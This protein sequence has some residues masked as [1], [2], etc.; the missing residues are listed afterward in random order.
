MGYQNGLGGTGTFCAQ[1]LSTVVHCGESTAAIAMVP[2]AA[3]TVVV[4]IA[5]ALA[6]NELVANGIGQS[7]SC[8]LQG[9]LTI[10]QCRHFA[11]CKPA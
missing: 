5:L 4:P 2:T 11:L 10:R 9:T 3:P 8:N 7:E 1:P 6:G